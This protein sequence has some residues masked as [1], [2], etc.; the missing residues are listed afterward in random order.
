MDPL[1]S[2][3]FVFLVFLVFLALFFFLS[4][5]QLLDRR[6]FLSVAQLSGALSGQASGGPSDAPWL[7]FETEE[8]D[9]ADEDEDEEE[10]EEEEEEV[11]RVIR[12]I[13]SL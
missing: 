11:I 10:D 1:K 13:V 6:R 2:R 4:R 7:H 3:A 5:S 9:D 8:D 12:V